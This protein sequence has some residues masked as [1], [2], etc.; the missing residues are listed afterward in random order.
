MGTGELVRV[1]IGLG[2]RFVE[3]AILRPDSVTLEANRQALHRMADRLSAAGTPVTGAKQVSGGWLLS[4]PP[5]APVLDF[6]SEFVNHPGS[7][8]TDPR[9]LRRYI[10]ARSQGELAWWD[11]LFAGVETPNP[12]G[13][14]DNLSASV[15]TVQRRSP[16]TALECEHSLR[17]QQT[18]GRVARYREDRT[19]QGT[20]C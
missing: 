12:R 16:R 11:I 6:V 2:N 20:G 18:A 7:M 3:T 9:P 14:T 17:D 1:S 10:E 5:V 19:D 8:L 15:L 4:V 13:R